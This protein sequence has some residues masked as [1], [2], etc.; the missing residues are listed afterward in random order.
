MADIGPRD[1]EPRDD[2]P[3]GPANP[4]QE[5]SPRKLTIARLKKRR[6]FLRVA[7][8]QCKGV[9]PGLILQAAPTPKAPANGP[10]ATR[11][12]GTP[13]PADSAPGDAADIRIGFTVSK[14]VGNAVARNR[15]KRRLRAVADAI[16]PERAEPGTDYVLIGRA[17]TVDRA[18]D[19]LL[20]DLRTAVQ[21]VGSAARGGPSGA[22]PAKK[23]RDR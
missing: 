7:A 12:P 23:A 8:R 2:G 6:D 14:K 21:R 18:F 11:S 1:A 10:H 22:K 4:C 13:D 16:M 9:T 19:A 20:N 17:A 15:A 3:A 5:L